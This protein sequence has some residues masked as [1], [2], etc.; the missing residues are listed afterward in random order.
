MVRSKKDMV[1]I[2]QTNFIWK[3]GVFIIIFIASFYSV[4]IIFLPL[5]IPAIIYSALSIS[6]SPF[7]KHTIRKKFI[8]VALNFIILILVV[9]S[10]IFLLSQIDS[11][12]FWFSDSFFNDVPYIKKIIIDVKQESIVVGSLAGQIFIIYLPII[13]FIGIVLLM[14]GRHKKKTLLIN[15][16]NNFI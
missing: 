10:F 1:L 14:L 11:L 3:L 16:G 7:Y 9:I 6:G 8:P 4:F 2:Y 13:Y 12:L 5:T 15:A